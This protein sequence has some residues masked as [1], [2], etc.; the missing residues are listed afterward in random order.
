MKAHRFL[1]AFALSGMVACVGDDVVAPKTIEPAAYALASVAG[2]TP[3]VTFFSQRAEFLAA[4]SAHEIVQTVTFDTRDDGTPISSPATDVGFQSLTLSDVTFRNVVDDGYGVRSYFNSYL[5]ANWTTGKGIR[6]DLPPGTRAVGSDMTPFYNVPAVYEIVLSNGES[7]KYQRPAEPVPNSFD[8]LGV[9][10]AEPI[11]YVIF[12]MFSEGS[13]FILLNDLVVAVDPGSSNQAPLANPG[14]NGTYS[15]GE[16]TAIQFDGSGSSAPD[17][18][19]LSYA[20][21]FGDGTSG[22]GVAPTHAYA[23]NGSYA[24]TLTVNDGQGGTATAT[25][26]ATV[27]NVAPSVGAV[28]APLDPQLVGTT[29]SVSAPFTDPGA[30]DAHAARIDWGNGTSSSGS[31]S[32][33]SAGGSHTYTAAGV[34]TVTVE[35]TD[36][37]GG[38]ASSAFQYVVVYDPAAG[39][40]TGGGWIDS[41]AGAYA[42]DPALSGKASFGFVSRY[43]SGAT[44]PSGTTQF[45]FKAGALDFHSASYEWLVVSGPKAQYKGSGAVNGAGDYGFLLTAND[46]QVSGG[47]GADKFRIKIWD[48]ATG[49]VVYDNRM[50][51]ADDASASTALGGGSI[52]IHKQ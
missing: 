31:V 7:F 32:A 13:G 12:T 21:D 26:T 47:G 30:A 15:G 36:D 41:P 33:G 3:G 49:A 22:T 8:F 18:D 17:G 25:A 27:A 34:Y 48:K 43:Q 5:Y 10:S 14:G 44:K 2:T 11:D 45:Q 29:V 50:G 40:V 9:T 20:W 51:E 42:A 35:V 24:V 16:G 28:T 37:D 23:D 38:S 52:A 19:A 1:H 4:A 46:G 6:V 39:F